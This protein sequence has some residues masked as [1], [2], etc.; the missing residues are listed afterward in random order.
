VVVAIKQPESEVLTAPEAQ[1]MTAEGEAFFDPGDEVVSYRIEV[2][3]DQC[4]VRPP[5]LKV[6]LRRGQDSRP[7]RFQ[8]IARKSGARSLV[9][10]AYQEDDSLAAQ[11][12]IK[13]EA[14]VRVEP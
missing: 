7:A 8:V 12:E 2:S 6:K 4:E 14:K 13:I 5:S 9:V 10:V 3:G 1:V 11:T